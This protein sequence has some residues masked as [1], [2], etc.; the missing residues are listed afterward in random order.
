MPS[1]PQWPCVRCGRG[2]HKRAAACRDC[3]SADPV[4]VIMAANAQADLRRRE[5]KTRRLL[6]APAGRSWWVEVTRTPEGTSA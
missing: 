1:E 4:A 6:A 5:A 2:V 3:R